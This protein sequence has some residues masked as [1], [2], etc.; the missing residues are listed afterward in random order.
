LLNNLSYKEIDMKKE[1]NNNFKIITN[2]KAPPR[3][4]PPKS[5]WRDIVGSMKAG[6]WF[7]V[8]EVDR[9]RVL[10][11]CG[12]YARGRYSLYQHPEIEQTYVFTITK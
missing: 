6:D 4:T 3:K 11:G 9:A 10:V 8:D 5:Q 2:K 12:K 1:R 7:I